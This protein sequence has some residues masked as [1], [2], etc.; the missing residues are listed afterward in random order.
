MQKMNSSVRT[1]NTSKRHAPQCLCAYVKPFDD[2]SNGEVEK[3][4]HLSNKEMD[5]E[6][7]CISSTWEAP[8]SWESNDWFDDAIGEEEQEEGEV[9]ERAH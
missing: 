7:G 6:H 5:I 8:A 4:E 9:A 1:R 3:I 2:Y